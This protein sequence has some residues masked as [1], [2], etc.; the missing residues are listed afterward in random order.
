MSSLP[1]LLQARGA[2]V[3][4]TFVRVD[5]RSGKEVLR[6]CDVPHIHSALALIIVLMKCWS[7]HHSC[8]VYSA[9]GLCSSHQINS[10]LK[11]IET[12]YTW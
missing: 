2:R 10:A 3:E 9:S 8:V 5:W 4:L 6:Q 11:S 1:Q 7:V 12:K